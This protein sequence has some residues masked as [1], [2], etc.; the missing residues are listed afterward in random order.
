[1]SG[2][3]GG[4]RSDPGRVEQVL[5]KMGRALRPTEKRA[6][7]HGCRVN[8]PIEADLLIRMYSALAIVMRV[9]WMTDE[10]KIENKKN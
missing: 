3:G 10:A 2:G 8:D 5:A 4:L 7:L 6:R 1:M 9:F